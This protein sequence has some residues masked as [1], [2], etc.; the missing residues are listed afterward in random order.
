MNIYML[1]GCWYAVINVL[2]LSLYGYDKHAAINNKWRIPEKYL[3]L[4]SVLGGWLT[5]RFCQHGF[6][7]KFNKRSFMWRYWATVLLHFTLLF[8]FYQIW[9]T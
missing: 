8:G 9:N 7:H 4:I 3:H 1:Y 6:R 5:A 2:T